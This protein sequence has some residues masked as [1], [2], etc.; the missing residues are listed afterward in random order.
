MSV[1][2]GNMTRTRV[3][4]NP[5]AAAGRAG[6][7]LATA[8]DILGVAWPSIDWCVS[9]NP[10]HLLALSQDAV[11]RR[12][13]R[14]IIAG[15]DGSIS[16]ALRAF[17]GR[18][19][20]LGILPVGTGNDFASAVGMPLNIVEAARALVRGHVRSVDLG[21]VGG[22]PFCCVVG[23]G[24]DTP[25][26][27]MI[28]ASRFKRGKLLYQYAAVRT[29]LSYQPT[30]LRIS[31]V[32]LDAEDK[33]LFAA[34]C[35]TPTYAGGHRIAPSATLADGKLNYCLF[36]DRP[37]VARLTTF[38]RVRRGQH[39]E[40]TGVTSGNTAAIHIAGIDAQLPITIDGEL[41]NITTPLSLRA[42]P[43]ALRLICPH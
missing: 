6:R 13:D 10:A 8:R 39:V 43:D 33:F 37:L 14:V 18:E 11:D 21:E 28:N 23:I 40:S 20:A 22:I 9:E 42:L 29:L 16:C 34:V 38:A 12:F 25:A 27:K 41:A 32:G 19:T 36:A 24:M 15:G 30:A 35:N 3:I 2:S 5:S 26:L 7:R 31:T 17:V 4:L 1:A